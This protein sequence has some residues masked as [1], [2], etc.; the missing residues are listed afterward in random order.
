MDLDPAPAYTHANCG[1]ILIVQWRPRDVSLRR[2]GGTTK[3]LPSQA[4]YLEDE[5]G[6]CV[7]CGLSGV[8]VNPKANGSG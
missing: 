3:P 1:G 5:W 7:R 8:V 6:T 2:E 4:P